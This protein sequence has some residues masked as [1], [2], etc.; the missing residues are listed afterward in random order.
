VANNVVYVMGEQSKIQI[1]VTQHVSVLQ[2]DTIHFMN[3]S[4]AKI[5]YS[6]VL[7]LMLY[8]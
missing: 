3:N 6:V 5:I 1:S 4:V 7:I 2:Q 8:N